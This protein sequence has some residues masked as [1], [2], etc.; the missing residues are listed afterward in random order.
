M[1]RTLAFVLC[2]AAGG[3]VIDDAP[4]GADEQAIMAGTL[5]EPWMVERAIKPQFPCTATLIAPHHAL[6]ALHCT[7]YN[8]PGTTVHFYTDAT[9]Y[10]PALAR[11]VVAVAL[12]PG[13]AT[14]PNQDLIDATGLFADIAVLTLDADAPATSFPSTLAWT[15]PGAG[16]V[17]TV[18]G[19]GN[20]DNAGTNPDGELRQKP[21]TTRYAT[22]D[23]GGIYTDQH[24]VNG[25]DSGGPLYLAYRQ[26]GVLYGTSYTSVPEHLDWI[27]GQIGYAWPGL[28]AVAGCYRTGTTLE[29]FGDA[30]ERTCQYACQHTRCEAYNFAPATGTCVLMRGLTGAV[31]TPLYRT[32]LRWSPGLIA[33]G[34]G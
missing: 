10:D 13:T 33:P 24:D 34:C 8:K 3:C 6:T 18:V 7:Q 11:Q 31:V 15:Y 5:A 29:T 23:S 27:L 17:V 28:A 25:G 19:A 1:N 20:H 21:Q 16:A 2:A 30:T 14:A 32:A 26:L 12:R 9:G 22:D 4:L